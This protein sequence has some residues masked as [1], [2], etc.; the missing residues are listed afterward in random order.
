MHL[1]LYPPRLEHR[2]P[3]PYLLPHRDW[4]AEGHQTFVPAL[5]T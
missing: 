1:I 3:R 5:R 4:Q 2:L